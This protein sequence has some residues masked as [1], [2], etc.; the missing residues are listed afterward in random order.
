[1]PYVP[2]RAH[3]RFR[4]FGNK[5]SSYYD[6]YNL[7]VYPTLRLSATREVLYGPIVLLKAGLISADEPM[8]D[9]V[10]D[11]WEDNLTLSS[12]SNFNVHGWV[13]D[14]YWFSRGGMVFQ[15]NLQNPVS[16]YLLRNEIPATI[17]GLYDNFVSCLFPDV[18]AQTEEYRQWVRGSGPFYKCPDEARFVS[19]VCD[20]L[21]VEKNDELWLAAGTPRRWLDAGQNIALNKAATAYGELSY[22]LHSGKLPGT[23]E[24]DIDLP[25]HEASKVILYVRSPDGM[26]MKKVLINGKEAAKWDAAKESIEIPQTDKKVNVVVHY[27]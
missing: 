25:K 27:R 22:S 20:L 11:D 23:I 9:W 16:T 14:E 5:K 8:A 26:P 12:S 19:Q 7:S 3:Q 21:V 4:L 1:V 17:R 13:D 10:L 18:N 15:A 6:R 24:A 2:S